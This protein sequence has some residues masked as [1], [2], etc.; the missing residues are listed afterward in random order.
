[1]E[2]EQAQTSHESI[3]PHPS[4][5]SGGEVRKGAGKEASMKGFKLNLEPVSSPSTSALTSSLVS[6]LAASRV[7]HNGFGLRV[8]RFKGPAEGGEDEGSS[9]PRGG[10]LGGAGARSPG[11]LPRPATAMAPPSL[12]PAKEKFHMETHPWVVPGAQT[13]PN[14]GELT[15]GQLTAATPR[16]EIQNRGKIGRIGGTAEREVSSTL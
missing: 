16:G 9:R 8:E 14:D 12:P 7:V 5:S 13:S 15:H 11:G 1:M 4:M 6:S 2:A 10:A 3:W